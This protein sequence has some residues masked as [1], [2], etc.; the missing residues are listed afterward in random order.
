MLVECVHLQVLP[1]QVPL[2]LDEIFLLVLLLNTNGLSTDDS[3]RK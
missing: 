1:L 3:W 2:V